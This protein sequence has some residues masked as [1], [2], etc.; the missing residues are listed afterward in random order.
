MNVS[1]L[2]PKYSFKPVGFDMSNNLIRHGHDLDQTMASTEE[3]PQSWSSIRLPKHSLYWWFVDLRY[4][5]VESG[6][7][8]SP[9]KWRRTY[10]KHLTVPGIMLYLTNCIPS[11]CVQNSVCLFTVS[12]WVAV[13]KWY[14]PLPTLPTIFL[15]NINDFIISKIDM[16]SSYSSSIPIS[17]ADSATSRVSLY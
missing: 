4:A 5:T 2:N 11:D 8:V 6:G 3:Q 14:P 7:R 13:S 16:H 17:D 1:T 12:S 15:L 9:K 10:R